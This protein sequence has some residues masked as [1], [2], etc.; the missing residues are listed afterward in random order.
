MLDIRFIREN[1]EEVQENAHRKG[2]DVN[3]EELLRLD[4][5]RRQLQGR[6]EEL[7]ERRNSIAS[8]MKGGKPSEMQNSLGPRARL[9]HS[10]DS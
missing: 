7:R 9:R 3:I 5:S 1:A 6:V 10:S 2:Y 4:S 8:Q